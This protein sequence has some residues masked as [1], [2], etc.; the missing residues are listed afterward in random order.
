MNA[1]FILRRLIAA[2]L[3]NLL[4]F[5]RRFALGTRAMVAQKLP[6]IDAMLMAVVPLK[7]DGILAHGRDIVRPDRRMVHRQCSGRRLNRRTNRASRAGALFI[8]HGARTSIAQPG[9]AIAAHVPV[10][11]ENFHPCPRRHV[12]LHRFRVRPGSQIGSFRA[13][14]DFSIAYR[15]ISIQLQQNKRLSTLITD[16]LSAVLKLLGEV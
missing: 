16:Y 3:T 7:A 15:A 5:T 13:T 10:F 4:F 2:T 1:D 12:D 14:H 8:A 6:G 9:E 11:P